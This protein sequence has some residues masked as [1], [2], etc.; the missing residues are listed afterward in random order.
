MWRVGLAVVRVTD[1]ALHHRAG[2]QVVLKRGA[3]AGPLAAIEAQ[4]LHV[5]LHRRSA[6]L[7]FGAAALHGAVEIA[8]AASA[9]AKYPIANNL[10]TVSHSGW[11]R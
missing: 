5:E 3:E 2:Q 7:G 11:G 10:A 6:G 8:L 4:T 9:T 1:A